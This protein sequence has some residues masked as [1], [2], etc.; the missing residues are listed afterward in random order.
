LASSYWQE[1]GKYI[2]CM[3]NLTVI[4]VSDTRQDS[5]GKRAPPRTK[6]MSN[7]MRPA[8]LCFN[9]THLYGITISLSDCISATIPRIS[10]LEYLADFFAFF[11]LDLEQMLPIYPSNR[12]KGIVSYATAPTVNKRVL[13]DNDKH[14][15]N[16]YYTLPKHTLLMSQRARFI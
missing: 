15:R 16:S 12:R 10:R 4:A 13:I 2:E 5:K 11:L 14:E 9:P 1:L 7:V 6:D 3:R 8:Y